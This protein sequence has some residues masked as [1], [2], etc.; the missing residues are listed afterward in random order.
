MLKMKK[1]LILLLTISMSCSLTPAQTDA[2]QS[3]G[4]SKSKLTLYVGQSANLRVKNTRKKVKWWSSRES[5]ATVTQKGKV[6]AKKQGRC[7]IAAKVAGKKYICR[8]TVKKKAASTKKQAA[9]V[10][11]TDTGSKY[12]R[13]GCRYLWNSSHK[14]KLS[15]AKSQGYSACS[16]CW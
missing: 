4:L 9:Y 8:V 11:V 7:R 15:S 12:H 13:A 3:V 6:R 5:T 10:Y 2:A 14:M 1:L 16:V